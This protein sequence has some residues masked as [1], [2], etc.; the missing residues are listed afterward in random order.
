MT[1]LSFLRAT[2][3]CCFCLAL[4][5][6]VREVDAEGKPTSGF[7]VTLDDIKRFRQIDSKTPGHPEFGLTSGVETTTGPLGQ[8][9]GNSVGMAIAGLWLAARY[10]RPG[11]EIFNYNVYSI[12]SDGDLMEGVGS[13]AAS[14]AGHLRLTQSLLD[15]RQQ[16]SHARRTCGTVFIAQKMWVNASAATDG[17]W[18]TSWMPT[19]PP[20]W[21]ALTTISAT[22]KGR[23]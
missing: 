9:V 3:P 17:M 10:N 14:L 22:A 13:E 20:P 5:G 11:F 6:E 15:L 21:R 4:P 8:G 23:P 16:S 1:V 12:C 19:I 18:S 7:A 2:H